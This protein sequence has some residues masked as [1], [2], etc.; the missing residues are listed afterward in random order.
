MTRPSRHI[1]IG[2]AACGLL[3]AILAGVLGYSSIA[4]RDVSTLA[5]SKEAAERLA[6]VGKASA[7]RG[8]DGTEALA[9]LARD[10]D[11]AV[12]TQAIWALGGRDG[13]R[14]Q[15]ALRE[16]LADRGLR[17][18]IRA[19]AAAALGRGDHTDPE[20]LTRAL[21]DEGDET[22]RAGAAKGLVRM[23]ERQKDIA[24]ARRMIPQLAASLE[25]PSPRVRAM[26]IAA[27]RRLVVRQFPFD[28][29]APVGSQRQQ[30]EALRQYLRKCG[31]M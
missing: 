10:A 21:A 18:G 1:L 7:L 26:A 22:V 5:G 11:A 23:A 14:S 4:G 27:I 30:V 13:D 29:K 19:E 9:R 2:G 6:A 12:A 17:P 16:L 8:D 25:D 28:P 3:V 20:V 31:A 15:A 24:G